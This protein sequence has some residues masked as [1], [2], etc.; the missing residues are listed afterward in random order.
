M[1]DSVPSE[2]REEPSET[3]DLL[4]NGRSAIRKEAGKSILLGGGIVFLHLILLGVG[5][6]SLR[7]IFRSILFVLGFAIIA[8][9]IWEVRRARN[10]TLEDLKPTEQ[11]KVFAESLKRTKPVYTWIILACLIAVGLCQPVFES[12]R[13]IEAAGLVKG[14][15][16]Q[17]EWWRLLTCA[18][19]HVNFM[20]IWMNGQALLGLGRLVELV[21]SRYHLCL[22]FLLSA[23]CGSFFSLLL[24]PNTTSAGASGGLM[25]LVG[26]LAVLGYRRKENLPRK[27][28]KSIIISICFIGVIG[29]IGF[30]IIDNAAHL[31]GLIA[32]AVCGAAMIKIDRRRAIPVEA[33]A[34]VKLLG[35]ASFLAIAGISLF[36]ILKIL[37]L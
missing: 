2:V 17:G 28:F 37:H 23:L 13:S 12:K 32:G 19:L 4:E 25:G 16:R 36:S 31:G 1:E 35:F 34:A 22:T 21:A 10:L 9:G 24:L 29:L 30:A 20:H 7:V 6:I 15:V 26:F 18:T 3:I 8:E 5:V 14:A 33:G 11:E 27:F